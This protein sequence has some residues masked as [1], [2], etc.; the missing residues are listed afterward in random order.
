MVFDG[1]KSQAVNDPDRDERARIAPITLRAAFYK[2]AR[3]RCC[4]VSQVKTDPRRSVI[5]AFS[6]PRTIVHTAIDESLSE[7]RREQEVV[8]AACLCRPASDLVL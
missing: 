3:R 8:R 6:M 2:F 7:V 1:P 5:A 4:G